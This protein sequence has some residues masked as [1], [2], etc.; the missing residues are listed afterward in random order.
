MKPIPTHLDLDEIGEAERFADRIMDANDI[1]AE[2]HD[3]EWT[4]EQEEI[5]AFNERNE[6]L[7]KSK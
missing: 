3:R 6:D 5:E 1:K 4:L 7:R 2:I